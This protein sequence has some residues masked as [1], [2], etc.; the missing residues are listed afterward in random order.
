VAFVLDASATLPWC[1][2]DE[3][4]NQTEALLVRATAGET[5]FV[6][7]HWSTEVLNVLLQAHRRNRISSADFDEFLRSLAHFSLEVESLPLNQ[8]LEAVRSLANR[9]R[10]TAYDAAYLELA[11]RLSLP[12]A[13]FDGDLCSAA[14][15]EGVKLVF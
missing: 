13:S 12:L 6:P 9:H 8:Y 2:R 7:P 4:T 14:R 15:A 10:L 5:L 1:F 3:A 11:Q